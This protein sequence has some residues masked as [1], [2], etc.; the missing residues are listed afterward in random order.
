[1]ATGISLVGNLLPEEQ[2]LFTK[3]YIHFELLGFLRPPFEQCNPRNSS[4]QQPQQ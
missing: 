3:I 1:M 2:L 4:Q